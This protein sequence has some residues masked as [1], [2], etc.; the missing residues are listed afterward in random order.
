MSK[1]WLIVIE[2]DG[3]QMLG[4]N[5]DLHGGLGKMLTLS[6]ENGRERLAFMWPS[7]WELMSSEAGL[8]I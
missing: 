4:Y 2:W 8:E 5:M 7:T 6:V 1:P 3:D